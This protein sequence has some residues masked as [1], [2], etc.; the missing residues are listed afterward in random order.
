[1]VCVDAL[2]ALCT[3]PIRCNRSGCFRNIGYMDMTESKEREAYRQACRHY[4]IEGNFYKQSHAERIYG[5]C[6]AVDIACTPDCG[7]A[8]MKRFD[9]RNVK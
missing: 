1:M 9:K 5:Y 6:F 4:G 3:I 2:A 8:R 7:C